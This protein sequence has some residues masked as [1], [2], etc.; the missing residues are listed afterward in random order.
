M[1]LLGFGDR[2]SETAGGLQRAGLGGVD[3]GLFHVDRRDLRLRFPRHPEYL[4][5]LSQGR[6]LVIDRELQ[7]S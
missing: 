3:V 7:R 6:K 1:H 5:Q 2:E 4:G